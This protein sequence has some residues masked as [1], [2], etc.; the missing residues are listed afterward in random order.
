MY[1]GRMTY[2]RTD[3]LSILPA[4]LVKSLLLTHISVGRKK[5]TVEVFLNMANQCG[6]FS[7]SLRLSTLP[8]MEQHTPIPPRSDLGMSAVT[9]S[10]ILL[11]CRVQEDGRNTFSFPHLNF[12]TV[13]SFFTF[14][15]I[16]SFLL[17]F[18]V[19]WVEKKSSQY[20]LSNSSR[21]KPLLPSFYQ[22]SI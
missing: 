13:S 22:S 14:F 4:H 16:P 18:F 3:E 19:K 20:P 6:L 5:V 12:L 15:P 21:I 1:Y 8:L 10:S 2:W 7:R 9:V 17:R 11:P